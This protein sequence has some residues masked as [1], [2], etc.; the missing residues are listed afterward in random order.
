MTFKQKRFE[1]D[2]ASDEPL[3]SILSKKDLR[4]MIKPCVPSAKCQEEET[5]PAI[6]ETAKIFGRYEDDILRSA[7][8]DSSDSILDRVKTLHHNLEFYYRKLE[9]QRYPFFGHVRKMPG[10]KCEYALVSETR[11]YW[12]DPFL[13]SPCTNWLQPQHDS[14]LHSPH[15]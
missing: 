15:L 8:S 3:P 10:C 11:R 4:L 6:R 9:R 13:Q 1:D 2:I 5:V 12:T 14:G 7:Q